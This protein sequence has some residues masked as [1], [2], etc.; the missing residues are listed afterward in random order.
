MYSRHYKRSKRPRFGKLA[1]YENNGGEEIVKTDISSMAQSI[2]V[3]KNEVYN[4]KPVEF[5]GGLTLNVSLR[6]KGKRSH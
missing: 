3:L 4:G 2:Y 5:L 6:N 1:N